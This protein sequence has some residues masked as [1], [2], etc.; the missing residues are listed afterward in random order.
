MLR[1]KPTLLAVAILASAQ[2]S[3]SDDDLRINGF[4]SVGVGMLLTLIHI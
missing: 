4:M 3:A 1:I 2:A